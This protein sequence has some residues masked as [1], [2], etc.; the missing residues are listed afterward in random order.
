MYAQLCKRLADNAPNFDPTDSET[1]TFRRLLLSKCRD[2]FE[3]RSKL[4][5]EYER[6][7]AAAASSSSSSSAAASSASPA[8]G[9][10]AGGGGPNV[11]ADDQID[12]R[13][14]GRGGGAGRYT[15]SPDGT[16]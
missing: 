10:G 11:D 7:V 9:G 4:A 8:G 5:Q 12:V 16:F 1:T 15:W 6:A 13:Y 14:A 3:N 2:E